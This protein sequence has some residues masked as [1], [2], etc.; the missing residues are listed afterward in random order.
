MLSRSVWIALSTVALMTAAC[1]NM[2]QMGS[3]SSGLGMESQLKIEDLPMAPSS[4]LAIAPSLCEGQN[5]TL[6]TSPA[7]YQLEKGSDQVL[8]VPEN[9]RPCR[10]TLQAALAF[11]RI[12]VANSVRFLSG[13]EHGSPN[14]E[15]TPKE[16]EPR[17]D[18]I[19]AKESTGGSSHGSTVDGEDA[20]DVILAKKVDA[21]SSK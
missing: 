15:S 16:D 21:K 7:L 4:L 10:G 5:K 18:P 8:V 9:S 2:D 19:P 11:A 17:D 20:D 14:G 1:G 6:R 12:E 3:D 13:P